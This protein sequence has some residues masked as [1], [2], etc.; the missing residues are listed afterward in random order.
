MYRNSEGYP[1]PTFDAVL[2]S[3][4]E[5]KAEEKWEY[6]RKKGDGGDASQGVHRF[7]LRRRYSA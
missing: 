2:R 7:S 6:R 4:G 3:L 1:D 5:Q